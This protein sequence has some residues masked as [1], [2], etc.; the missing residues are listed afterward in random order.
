MSTGEGALGCPLLGESVLALHSGYAAADLQSAR[1]ASFQGD[2]VPRDVRSAPRRTS[3][4]AVLDAN[5]T[6]IRFYTKS[7]SD[8]G[9]ASG[10][11]RA[12]SRAL[13][14]GMDLVRLARALRKRRIG[15]AHAHSS[16]RRRLKSP[17]T[18]RGG[19]LGSFARSIRPVPPAS[20]AR[21][22]DAC[23]IR[24][25]GVR[26]YLAALLGTK[27]F[28]ALRVRLLH[29]LSPGL[30]NG[31]PSRGNRIFSTNYTVTCASG[32]GG[33]NRAQAARHSGVSGNCSRHQTRQRASVR[34]ATPS[35]SPSRAA[36]G[37]GP[38]GRADTST[39]ASPRYARRPR[40]RTDIDVERR[41]QSAQQKLRRDKKSG[42][43][44]P[45]QPRGL[46]G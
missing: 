42:R 23:V 30:L 24:L 21:E 45:G 25:L 20:V 18:A 39:T 32:T 19:E 1:R 7:G 14:R 46:R 3:C 10:R 12:Q 15:D 27:Q 9:R 8:P 35:V 40:N 13:R 17:L 5:A 26:Q 11:S 29:R 22:Q 4:R 33:M 44:S 38:A 41:R 36:A 6:A 43:T 37:V 16:A 34:R 31:F 28:R 2:R